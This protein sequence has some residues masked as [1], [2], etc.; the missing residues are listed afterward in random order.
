MHLVP[1]YIFDSLIVDSIVS[2]QLSDLQYKVD[3]VCLRSTRLKRSGIFTLCVWFQGVNDLGVGSRHGNEYPEGYS[4]EENGAKMNN[5]D[6]DIRLL[7]HQSRAGCVIG[8]GGSKI[9]ELRERL[10]EPCATREYR[11]DV[12]EP[13]R[14]DTWLSI[15]SL[16]A[17]NGAQPA[18]AERRARAGAPA[19]AAH[20][21]AGVRAPPPEGAQ[22]AHAHL[23][24]VRRCSFHLPLLPS[25][26][27]GEPAFLRGPFIPRGRQIL[28][29]GCRVGLKS[30]IARRVLAGALRAAAADAHVDIPLL[31]MRTPR[32]RHS[33]RLTFLYPKRRADSGISRSGSR[34]RRFFSNN[35]SDNPGVVIH[36]SCNEPRRPRPAPPGSVP[37]LLERVS[38]GRMRLDILCV[39]ETKRKGSGGAIERG[40]FDTWSGADQSQRG[41]RGVGFILSKRLSECVNGFILGVYASDMSKPLG[42]REAFWVDVMD[43]LMKCDRNEKIVMLGDFNGWE[44]VKRDGYE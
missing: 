28:K 26:D 5:D 27:N 2:A 19:V 15:R 4:L 30:D 22:K 40:C 7:I 12:Q 9:K 18:R 24:I 43:I 39:N 10:T 41:C 16:C 29:S 33:H 14:A 35:L 37:A 6:L 8:K 25:F 3:P 38:V 20:V 32:S 36:V 1:P 17:S 44:G 23:G 34:R 42:K 11:A 13:I 31:R 21:A